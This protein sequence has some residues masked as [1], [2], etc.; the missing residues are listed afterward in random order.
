MSIETL[1]AALGE[2][3]AG[4]RTEQDFAELLAGHPEA[5]EFVEQTLGTALARQD[6]DAV[7]LLLPVCTE[8]PEP[9]YAQVLAD[10]L[11]RQCLEI[12]NRQLVAALTAIASPVALPALE[13][14]LERTTAPHPDWVP[15]TTGDRQAVEFR[16]ACTQAI[17]AI[18]T[19]EE[20]I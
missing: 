6:W 11:D 14:A 5:A 2:A 15:D 12:S 20:H 8:H 9:G 17:A 3:I 4:R 10:I 7:D 18:T 19:R 13:R 1:A 16:D